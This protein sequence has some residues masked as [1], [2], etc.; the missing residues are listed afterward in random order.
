MFKHLPSLTDQ[1]NDCQYG[2]VDTGRQRGLTVSAALV[3]GGGCRGLRRW[4]E[5]AR[6]HIPRPKESFFVKLF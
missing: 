4:A 3:A 6:G 2:G 1:R 5:T